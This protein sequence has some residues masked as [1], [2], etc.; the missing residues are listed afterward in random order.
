MSVNNE[1]NEENN[2]PIAPKAFAAGINGFEFKIPV[3]LDLFG[4]SDVF[5]P[6]SAQYATQAIEAV[7]QANEQ[8][9]AQIGQMM[10]QIREQHKLLGSV[11]VPKVMLPKIDLPRFE[12]PVYSNQF[13]EIF[14][15]V[16]ETLEAFRES[17]NKILS[18]EVFAA[19][20]TL[21][22]FLPENLAEVDEDVT[23][24]QVLALV[25][26]DGIPLYVVPRSNIVRDLVYSDSASRRRGVLVECKELIF[27]DCR[28]VLN[29]ISSEYALEKKFFI[30]AGLNALEN[31][32]VEAAQAL[33]TNTLD[34]VHQNFWGLNKQSRT[35]ISNH[36]EGD[37]LPQLIKNMNFLDVFVFAPIWNS[38]MRFFGHAGEEPPAEYSRHAS[39]YGVSRRQ[40]KLENCI[41]A[42]MLV[43]SLL[44]YIDN[45]GQETGQ[46]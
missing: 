29:H 18:P 39:V 5:A 20:R 23:L 38:H 43:T 40:Y 14:A 41:Q 15:E 19:Y 28:V 27:E 2:E 21:G 37:E 10:K 17:I 13:S 12:L 25:R 34:T 9:T 11:V 42:L 7:R 26:E 16:S 22:K 24:K 44:V 4:W 46:V 30:L 33:F 6:I 31:G 45:F 3:S 8:N 32:H 36:A 35:A 1:I